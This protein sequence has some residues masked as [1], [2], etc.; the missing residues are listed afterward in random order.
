MGYLLSK[1]E[2]KWVSHLSNEPPIRIRWRCDGDNGDNLR[3]RSDLV[4]DFAGE[5]TLLLFAAQLIQE[6]L[7]AF[8]LRMV[9]KLFS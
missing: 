4:R 3:R 9:N 8:L 6:L 7:G 2:S 1:W 5:P